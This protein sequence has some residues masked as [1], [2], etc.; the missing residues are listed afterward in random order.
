MGRALSSCGH[1]PQYAMRNLDANHIKGLIIPSPTLTLV[2][3]PYVS[4]VTK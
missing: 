4:Q 3:D 2:K 1:L